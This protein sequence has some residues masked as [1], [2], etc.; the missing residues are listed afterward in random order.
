MT[1]SSIDAA[2]IRNNRANEDGIRATLSGIV[3]FGRA[4]DVC[5]RRAIGEQSSRCWI[6]PNTASRPL[7][8]ANTDT[9][10][11][12]PYR[13]F[14]ERCERSNVQQDNHI[15]LVCDKALAR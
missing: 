12:A 10:R 1:I 4:I 3:A 2:I 5:T 6:R 9:F 13:A 14:P 11:H 8:S 15:H 7:R